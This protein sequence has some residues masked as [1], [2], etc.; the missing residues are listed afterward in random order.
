MKFNL[1]TAG[2][3]LAAMTLFFGRYPVCWLF[4]G[5]N[6]NKLRADYKHH[7]EY[8]KSPTGNLLYIKRIGQ[9]GNPILVFLHGINSS[10]EQWQHQTQYFLSNYELILIDLPGHG[11][12]PEATDPSIR[13]MAI[14]LGSILRQ[15]NVQQPV[16]YGHSLGGMII[17][18]YCSQKLAPYPKAII[19]QNC[20]YTNPLKTMPI[21]PMSW[22]LQ[23][24]L[25]HP[26]LE[27]ISKR[28]TLFTALGYL[29]YTSGLSCL[30]YRLLLFSGKQSAATL[31]IMTSLAAKTSAKTSTQ[32]LLHTFG[33]HALD[34]LKKINIPCLILAAAADRLVDPAACIHLHKQIPGSEFALLPGGH[35]TLAEYP[36][37]TNLAIHRFLAGAEVN[38]CP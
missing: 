22:L 17:Q 4:S 8:I 30:L 36:Q 29:A 24:P 7:G 38:K 35:Q 14:D 2:Y 5:R 19:M 3:S 1:R 31:R 26:A 28:N 13:A 27:Q 18:E 9:S 16:L 11:A 23:K 37:S 25:I 20:S 34:T 10:C 12:S 32:M 33:F 15:L 6:P 21:G